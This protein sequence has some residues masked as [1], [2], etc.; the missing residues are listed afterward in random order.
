[1]TFLDKEYSEEKL[2]NFLQK[3]FLRVEIYF[4]DLS[5]EV[6]RETPQYGWEHILSNIGGALGNFY[7]IFLSRHYFLLKSKIQNFK[8]QLKTKCLS[9]TK[10][11]L[12]SAKQVS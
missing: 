12:K 3:N 5:Y 6:V 9:E 8:M 2:R 10:C 1:M 4:E 7:S 11:Q